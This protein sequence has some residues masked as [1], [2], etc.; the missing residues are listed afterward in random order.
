M[1]E[2]L[3]EEILTAFRFK[4]DLTAVGIS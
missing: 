3:D 1:V 2:F 4:V